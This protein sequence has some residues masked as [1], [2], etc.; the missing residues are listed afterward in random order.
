MAIFILQQINKANTALGGR[1]ANPGNFHTYY[2]HTDNYLVKGSHHSP[3][4]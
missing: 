4:E 1:P 3:I 2:D